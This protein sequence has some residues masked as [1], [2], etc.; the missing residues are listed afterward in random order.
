[1]RAFFVFYLSYFSNLLLCKSAILPGRIIRKG[2]SLILHPV[3]L[4]PKLVV[5]IILIVVLA[6][7]HS[8]LTPSQFLA[9]VI[10]SVTAFFIFLIVFWIIIVKL[11]RNPKSRLT[12][13]AI[14]TDSQRPEEGYRAA[15]D[16]YQQL[17]GSRGIAVSALRPSG[18][19]LIKGE[20]ISVMTRGDF[21]PAGTEVE[22]IAVEGSRI[23]VRHA[24]SSV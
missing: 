24:Q 14:L 3:I 13:M 21:I 16:V 1:M 5:I 9:A 15:S 11:M 19:I 2:L 22:I 10:I 18:V 6:I 12:K 7:L 20:R 8:V 4:V 17:M 23:F